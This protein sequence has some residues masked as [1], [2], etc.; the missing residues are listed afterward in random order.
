MLLDP[1]ALVRFRI[2]RSHFLTHLLT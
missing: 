2:I 1:A